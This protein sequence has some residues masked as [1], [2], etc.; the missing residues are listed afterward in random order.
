MFVCGVAR[1]SSIRRGLAGAVTALFLQAALC[2]KA[3]SDTGVHVVP[4]PAGFISF[5]LRFPDQCDAPGGPSVI[6]L[7]P[8]TWQRLQHVNREVNNAIWPEDDRRH[9]GRAEYWT[10]PTDGFGDCEDYAL[11]KRQR[12]LRLGFPMRALRIAVVWAPGPGRHAVLIA[13]TSGGEFVLD[14]VQYEILERSR[15]SYLWLAEESPSQPRSWIARSWQGPQQQ[16]MAP[17]TSGTSNN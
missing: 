15:T 3:Q 1:L 8:A 5:C 11:T 7:S 12:L 14:N 16:P 10:I 2:G 4:S 13:A 9:Y 17:H 6:P